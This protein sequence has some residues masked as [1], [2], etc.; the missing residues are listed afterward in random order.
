MSNVILYTSNKQTGKDFNDT[1]YSSNKKPINYAGFNIKID[2][3]DFY[4]EYDRTLLMNKRQSREM[5]IYI[6]FMDWKDQYC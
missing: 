1:I 5:E 6:T 3:Q 2:A 4:A